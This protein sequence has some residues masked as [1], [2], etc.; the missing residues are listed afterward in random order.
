MRNVYRSCLK[1]TL[2][3]TLGTCF[4]SVTAH[5]QHIWIDPRFEAKAAF[6]DNATL[7]DTDRQADAVFNVSPGLNMRIESAR[8]KGAVDY[9]W[10]YLYFVSDKSEESRHNLF[11]LIDAEVWE[12]HLT[13]SARASARQTFIDRGAGLSNTIANRSA[14]RRL[15][16]NYTTSANLKGG[17]RDYADW[18]LSYRYGLTLSPAD[19][20]DDET[21]TVNF[22]DSETHE[23]SASLGSGYRFNNFEWRLAAS[24]RDVYR[25]LD[26]NNYLYENASAEIWYKFN[27]HISVVGEYG[28]SKNNFQS[29]SLAADGTFWNAGFRW[30]PGPKL[31]L[32]LK[33]GKEG[34]R[35]TWYGRFQY[36]FGVR[37]DIAVSYTDTLSSNA[38]VL[39]DNLQTYSFSGDDGIIDT[40]GLPIDE[41]D[42]NFSLS[43]VD[44]RRR[45]TSA[46]LTWRHKRSQVYLNVNNEWRTFDDESGTAKT[47]GASLGFK[48][49]ISQKTNLSGTLSY[50]RSRFE[51]SFRIDNYIV[52]EVNWTKT[53]S[54]YVKAGISADHS[55]RISNEDGA[56][57]VENTLTLYL[58]GTF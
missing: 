49:K 25:S 26:V 19:N 47:A 37:M 55:E 23:F 30:N 35:K 34:N 32:T 16:Q 15:V 29:E 45:S 51:D 14:N 5:A 54:R 48:H 24:R 4:V 17:L 3:A 58:R 38:I 11:G 20:L 52:A 6:T 1:R 27:R 9:S 50:R 22:S 7:V 10:D 53:L 12:D 8:V 46:V 39:N 28:Y 44:F 57:L 56:D 40:S 21:L 41:T 42:P 33:R 2:L 13:V 31:D 43:D 36:F 18:K